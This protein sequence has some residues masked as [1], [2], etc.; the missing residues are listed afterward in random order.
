MDEKVGSYRQL[1][2]V[3]LGGNGIMDESGTI[4]FV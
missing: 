2:A 3:K 1:K 4:F